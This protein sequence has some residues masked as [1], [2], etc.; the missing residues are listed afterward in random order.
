M[1]DVS[2]VSRVGFFILFLFVL[3]LIVLKKSRLLLLFPVVF[4][5]MLISAVLT[6]LVFGSIHGLTLSFGT[7]IVG[8]ALDYGFQASL[9]SK[10]PS[11]WKTNFCGLC[12]TLAGL[13]VI[14]AS[15]VP[16]LRQMMFFAVVGLCS[17]FVVFYLLMTKFKTY[18][19]SSALD[20]APKLRNWKLWTSISMI[21]LS[22][23]G[24]LAL[25]PNLSL[26]QFDFQEQRNKPIQE[27][28]F[29][30]S[31]LKAPLFKVHDEKDLNV[32]EQ[33]KSWAATQG[34]SI[35]NYANYLPNHETQKAN[36]MTWSKDWAVITHS[37][38][39][40][41]NKFFEP[42]FNRPLP[43][44]PELPRRYL[45]H[46]YSNHDWI[47]LW[48]PKTEEQEQRI[49]ATF[50][51]VTSLKEVVS[52]FPVM[53]AAE[54]NWMFPLSVFLALLRHLIYYRKATLAV[55]AL[56]PFFTGVG[57]LVFAKYLFNLEISFITVVGLVMVFGFSLD[58]GIFATDA[59]RDSLHADR[60]LATVNGV[61]TGILFSTIATLAGFL[62]LMFCVHPVLKQLGQVLF[63]GGV[64]TYL[65]S[66][67][68]IPSFMKQL[69]VRA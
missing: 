50:P 11:V 55:I 2:I 57:T 13:F 17:S 20:C 52:Q 35:E 5:G 44:L 40:T 47:T 42:Y 61:W 65:G 22:F 15:E 68:G 14:M 30:T 66:V 29:K 53:L 10:M 54:L 43:V 18:F 31:G 3:L 33:E 26:Q 24:L 37:F 16:L 1:K 60:D 56:I 6:I 27:W 23:F 21:L 12:T 25:K 9:N 38:T 48:M 39:T 19:E 49:K 8:L 62:P 51:G 45:N 28:L 36:L 46:L 69:K 58:Y 7:G 64:G 41:Q 63:F 59:C 4:L 32:T 34:I 67:W